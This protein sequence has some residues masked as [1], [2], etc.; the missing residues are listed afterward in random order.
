M[1]RFLL[2]L[3]LV[4]GCPNAVEVCD[5]QRD[6][7]NNN[8]ADCDDP[9]CSADPRCEP[10]LCDNNLDDNANGLFDC[11]DPICDTDPICLIE[12]CHN[13]LDDSNDGL[14]DCDDPQ[15]DNDSGCHEF[16]CDDSLNN[17][18]DGA[19]DCADDDCFFD[20]VCG[21]VPQVKV[22]CPPESFSPLA[23]PAT[24]VST[25]T[26]TGPTNSVFAAW[27]FTSKPAGSTATINNLVTGN[28]RFTPDISGDYVGLFTATLATGETD[29]CTTTIHADNSAGIVFEISWNT[30]ADIDIHML[31]P[32]ATSWFTG[33]LDCNFTN[34]K[35]QFASWPGAGTAD[36][37]RLTIDQT[38]GP[39]SEQIFIEKPELNT[40]NGYRLGAY[41]SNNR[42]NSPTD[43]TA[44][45]FCSGT[46]V[47][48]FTH[49]DLIGSGVSAPPNELW[50]IADVIFDSP[51]TCNIIPIDQIVQTGGNGA[52]R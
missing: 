22:T 15:C 4:G 49:V 21:N 42:G 34:C 37:P 1:K 12:L 2:A 40:S 11:D 20:P 52:P 39:G 27:E 44:R 18:N 24:F 23:V 9:A 45:I 32:T 35:N 19:F 5:N 46:L 51:T 30:G 8:A 16:I 7:N 33:F 26:V 13:N 6:D 47:Q 14:V 31:H 48:S 43:V 28:A 36:D 17:D 41:N 25:T 50:K 38:A 10:E 29:S 3:F